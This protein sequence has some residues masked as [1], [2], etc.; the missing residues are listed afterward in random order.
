MGLGETSGKSLRDLIEIY[1]RF[2][3]DPD[4]IEVR[5]RCDLDEMWCV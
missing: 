4:E 3:G 1:V 2:M 5:F